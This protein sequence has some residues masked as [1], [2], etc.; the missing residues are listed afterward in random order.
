MKAA[1]VKELK[2][3]L[4]KCSYKELLEICL[5]L[6]K[7]KKENKELLTYLLY[8]ASDEAAYIEGIKNELDEQ[9]ELINKTS[10][11]FIK[12]GVRKILRGIKNYIRYSKKEET[13][14]HKKIRMNHSI[15]QIKDCQYKLDH[16][17]QTAEHLKKNIENLAEKVKKDNEEIIIEDMKKKIIEFNLPIIIS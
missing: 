7:F 17:T 9:F 16:Y 10:Y 12:K 13:E 6:S 11:F 14:L 3:E 5:R 1:T 8:E 2:D 4:N 15:L